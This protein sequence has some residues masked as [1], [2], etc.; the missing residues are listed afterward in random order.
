VRA[1]TDAS[2]LALERDD[3]LA[4]V[5]GH[6]RSHDAASEI[7]IERLALSPV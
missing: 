5:T 6:S 4:A 1:L 7:V 2:L 3:F